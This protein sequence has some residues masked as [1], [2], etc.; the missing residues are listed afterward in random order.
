[1]GS[2]AHRH[3]DNEAR[4]LLTRLER[5]KPFVLHETMVPAANV[6]PD[7]QIAMEDSLVAGRR[8]VR[9]TVH[10]FREWLNRGTGRLATPA[11]AQRRFSLLR[12]RFNAVL[13]RFDI[14]ADALSQRSEH[15]TGIW[16]S[17][18][19]VAADDALRLPGYY[20]NPPVVCYL[21]RGFGA[22]IRRAKTRL[23]GGAKN[24]VAVIRIPRERMVGSGI[25]SSLVHEVGHQAAALLGLVE[26]MRSVL[27]SR[28]KSNLDTEAWEMWERWIS[29]ILADFWSVS[30]LGAGSTI[31]LMGVLSLPRAFVFRINP[32]DPHPFPWIRVKISCAIG[33]A[34]Y[35]HRQWLRLQNL[36]ESYY[37]RTGMDDKKRKLIEQLEY[38]MPEFISLLL[39]HRPQSLRGTSLKEIMATQHRR[40]EK[41]MR[42]YRAWRQS[43]KLAKQTAPTTAFSVIGQARAPGV[44]SPEEEG[45]MVSMLL[46]H[47]ALASTLRNNDKYGSRCAVSN[48]NQP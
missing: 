26:S 40:P 21:D 47:W 34:L 29:E 15:T 12:L 4:A 46:R 43:P 13:M 42:I 1:M 24:P 22:A 7:A 6:S 35:P 23:P 48:I 9:T 45:R 14:F 37:P 17:G 39:N 27:R 41:L 20:S 5:V 44:M 16:L 18:L 10:R 38:T 30:R 25:A 31:G 2:S 36:W 28:K 8:K 3:L 11:Q 32:V 19:D 33:Q